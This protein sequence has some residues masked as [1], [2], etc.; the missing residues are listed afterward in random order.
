[1]C[2]PGRSETN[3]VKSPWLKTKAKRIPATMFDAIHARPASRRPQVPVDSDGDGASV[4][5]GA[6]ATTG[7]RDSACVKRI[8]AARRALVVKL[9]ATGRSRSIGVL[10]AKVM[11]H[12]VGLWVEI[13]EPDYLSLVV[14]GHRG[15]RS[16][17]A[18][19]SCTASLHVED[20]TLPQCVARGPRAP[21]YLSLI[22][23]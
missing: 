8:D 22:H 18:R 15:R 2:P 12:W 1:M 20:R 7:Y 5:D 17:G 6:P 16:N 19:W 11:S 21:R 3:V 14:I 13:L 4:I 9:P 10:R 23:I